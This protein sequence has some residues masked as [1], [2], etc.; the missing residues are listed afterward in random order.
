VVYSFC[1]LFPV[2]K[3]FHKKSKWLLS[4]FFLKRRPVGRR[5]CRVVL[6][7][8]A[9]KGTVLIVDDLRV[10]RQLLASVLVQYRTV[11]ADS[12]EA[13]LRAVA[14]DK[15][16]IILLDICMPGIDGF[17]VC[18]R[19]QASEET[20]G[21]PV[22]FITGNDIPGQAGR[23][24]DAGG[25]D[26]IA[27]PFDLNEVNA[28]VGTHLS[29][30][31]AKESLLAQN[32]LLEEKLREQELNIRL[33]N[34]VLSLINP[35]P[36]V[37]THLRGGDF[38]FA[39]VMVRSC[40]AAG[41]DHFM[42]KAV[43]TKDGRRSVICVK[44]QSGHAVNCILR[45]IIT[46][47]LHNSS[48]HTA[49]GLELAESVS[50]LNDAVCASSLFQ[51]DDFFTALFLDLDHRAK[52]LRYVSAGHPPFLL[53]RD[54]A[55]S[56]VPGRGETGENLPL[57]VH[58]GIE[59]QA[60][61]T[62]LRV[63]DRLL[64]FTDGLTDLPLPEGADKTLTAGDLCRV[65]QEIMDREG[66]IPVSRLME[67]LLAGLQ[68]RDGDD[69]PDD[70]TFMG[71]EV[72]EMLFDDRHRFVPA[73]F[74]GIDALVGHVAERV[75]EDMVRAGGRIDPFKLRM[76]LGEGITNAWKHG[77]GGDDRRPITIGWQARNCFTLMVE[78]CGRGFDF[79]TL[80]DPRR[81]E[82]RT[83]GSGRGIYCM[84]R[85]ADYVGWL[86]DGSV[87][88][89]AFTLFAHPWDVDRGGTEADIDLWRE[90]LPGF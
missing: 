31:R 65:A 28:R 76:V 73:D 48:L 49:P 14:A 66:D 44:D 89:L 81:L 87:L 47:L 4:V 30:K 20:A 86:G 5:R 58:E 17:E 68:P 7:Q 57:A 16:D 38:L 19:L 70:V 62:T 25:V 46:D 29:L 18:R 11:E 43:E 2:I 67:L 63:G 27:K 54:G 24:F 77:N 41:G 23:C 13:A 39:R 55:V 9:E 21:I 84:H 75:H 1:S 34:R 35:Y 82:N 12:G 53:I 32:R 90:P 64:L 50:L 78:D 3:I 71:L 79:Q 60:G 36:P 37:M 33:A 6:L 61:E 40:R 56:R 85:Y 74:G 52:R 51:G 59:Y 88:V 72:E 42:I 80:A 26:F 15:P 45:S 10:N 83:L 69:L 22:I 8:A